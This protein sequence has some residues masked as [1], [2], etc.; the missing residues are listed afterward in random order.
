ME[1][2]TQVKD[3]IVKLLGLRNANI[4]TGAKLYEGIGVDSTEMVEIRIALEKEFGVKLDEKEISKFQ[5]I[6]DIAA[7]IGS[8]KA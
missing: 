8:K 2:E 7:I 1:I 5:S 6:K 4:D 3:M